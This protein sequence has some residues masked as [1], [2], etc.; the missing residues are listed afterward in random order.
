MK[1][2]ADPG[3]KLHESLDQLLSNPIMGQAISELLT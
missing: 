2:T 3:S 1:K